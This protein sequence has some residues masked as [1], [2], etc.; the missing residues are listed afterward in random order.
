MK[1]KLQNEGNDILIFKTSRKKKTKREKRA[2]AGYAV[3][4]TGK[5]IV[6]KRTREVEVIIA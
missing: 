1:G 5:E 4:I 6:L 3:V 2:H